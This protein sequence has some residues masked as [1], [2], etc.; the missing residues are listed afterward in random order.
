MHTPHLQAHVYAYAPQTLQ[1]LQPVKH[2][3]R[4]WN[5]APSRATG[6][7]E[8]SS[9]KIDF[10]FTQVHV[11]AYAAPNA[12]AVAALAAQSPLLEVG[13]GTGYWSAALR[14]AGANILALD[15]TPPGPAAAAANT[16]HG[17]IPTVTEV[18]IACC[19]DWD[20]RSWRWDITP[21][22]Q[23]AAAA[24]PYHG[25]ILTVAEVRGV[26]DLCHE[27]GDS[28]ALEHMVLL[29]TL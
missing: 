25:Y 28:L 1:P 26:A 18:P 21:P 22:G 10:C 8:T 13:A 27:D 3:H 12:A 20:Q 5:W 14:A 23:A 16:Y 9:N 29:A 7:L 24:N 2:T 17:H 11:Y 4:C 6:R 15:I 19:H